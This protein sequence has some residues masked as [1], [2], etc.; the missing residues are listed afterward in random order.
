MKPSLEIRIGFRGEST[1]GWNEVDGRASNYAF[2]ANGTII[3]N[4]VVGSSALAV[5]NAK[6]LPAPRLGLAWS[7]FGSKKTVVRGGFGTYYA[8]LDNLSYRLD[9]NG[10]F[11]T[12]SAAK[13]IA[14]STIAP[15]ATYK[16]A[17]VIPSGIQPDL[18]TPTVESWSLKVEQQIAS[19]TTVSVGYVGS[20]GYHELLSVDANLPIGTIC[21][22]APCPANY[23]DRP[24]LL[25]D[26]RAA[27]EPFRRQHDALVLG[28]RQLLQRSRS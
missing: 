11:N 10:P 18:Q 3:T 6:F 16:S 28:G 20:H 2:D 15:G 27:G 13:S 21:P 8:L 23:P 17:K 14:F 24:A 22:A 1:N 12:V 19:S 25:P 4:P 7:P 26:R 5:N 9:Q